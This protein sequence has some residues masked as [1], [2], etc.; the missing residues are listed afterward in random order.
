MSR[1]E[2]PEVGTRASVAR[3]SALAAELLRAAGLR[4]PDAE[5]MAACLVFAQ[6]SGLNSHGL[7]HLPAYLRGLRQGAIRASFRLRFVGRREGVATLDAAGAPGVLAA[8]AASDRAVRLA[9]SAGV[10]AV[11]VRNSGHFGAASA[12][13]HRM[14]GQGV[15]ALVLSNAS[16]SVAPR[17]GR[18]ARL[19]TNPLAAGFPRSDGEPVIIDLATTQGS[20]AR[21]RKAALEGSEIPADWA[22]DAAGRPTR[23]PEAAL[24]G[25]MQA[26]GGAKGTALGLMVELLCVGLSGGLPGGAVRPPQDAGPAGVSHLFLAFDPT[27]FGGAKALSDK[28]SEIAG[29]LESVAPSDPDAPVRLPGARAAAARRR[30]E[31]EGIAITPALAAALAKARD[32]VA[33]AALSAAGG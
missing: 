18:E 24:Q 30:A 1:P 22:L 5:A 23:D 8:L 25:T 12:F 7:M 32:E 2:L 6:A 31:R 15:V 13:V 20:R 14:V 27:A 4:R 16:P 11:A 26:L 29:G 19:G 21:I 9:G 3:L 28:I 33:V 17:G 10:G